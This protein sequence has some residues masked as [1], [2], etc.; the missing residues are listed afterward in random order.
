[1]LKLGTSVRAGS[2]DGGS[3]LGC[4]H[5]LRQAA[6]VSLLTLEFHQGGVFL[7]RLGLWL[8]PHRAKPGHVFV[9]HAHSDHTARHPEA[10]LTEPTAWLMRHRLGGKRVEHILGYGETREFS[11]G[12]GVSPVR[13]CSEPTLFGAPGPHGQDARATSPFRLT[14]LPAGHILGS[15]MAFIEAGGE[16]LLY[17]GDFKLRP[18]LAADVCEPRHADHLVMETTF[19]RP[20]YI[21]PPDADVWRDV[22]MFCR[23]ALAEGITPVLFA[24]AL[25]K[26]QELLAGLRDAGLPIALHKEA[27]KLTRINEHF[28]H[29]FP[30]FE[31][32]DGTNAGGKVLIA[33]SQSSRSVLFQ[34]LGKTRT[35]VVTGWAMDSS[36]RFRSG[37]DAAFPLSDHADYPGLIEFVKRVAPKKVFTLHGFAADFART[38]R[39][40]GF[41]AQSLS[42]EEQL[43]LP[44][45]NLR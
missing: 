2:V 22:V 42:E 38:L 17:T 24:Y 28:G 4:G 13:S 11:S 12:T 27:A 31:I 35:A 8:D 45:G 1:M 3:R 26:S 25:G 15:A 16:S 23:N 30:P 32:F 43:D 20:K 18:G 10:I 36:C 9:S 34:Q 19:G 7:P 44:L 39:E 21:F 41:D 29:T 5:P 6:R 40:H 33:P 37:T 14:L